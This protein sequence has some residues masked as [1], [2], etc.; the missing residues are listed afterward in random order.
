MK[1]RDTL[2]AFSLAGFGLAVS[3]VEAAVPAPPDVKPLKI[4]GGRQKFEAERDA[5][6]N[7]EK[8][9]TPHELQTVTV[10]SDIIIPADERSGSASQAG[11][12]AFIEFMMKDQPNNQTPMRGGIRWLDNTCVKRYGKQ[13][14]LCTKA[15]QIDLVEQIAYPK[16]VKP[17][18]TQGA[19]FFSMMRN[20]TATGFYTSQ[21]GIKDI[22]Y[23][24]NVPNQWDG[25]PDEVL[26]Q[27]G[28]AYEERELTQGK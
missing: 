7:A 2:K 5:K 24:G 10:L 23:V 26:K 19:A 22:G 21:M 4:P 12:P 18:M 17:D 6:L 14:V 3:P 11:V 15:Q 27:Y 28:L 13:F 8:F 1:R 9:F 20:L 25:V 16:Q